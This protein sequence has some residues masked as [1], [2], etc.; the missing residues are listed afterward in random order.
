MEVGAQDFE[1]VLYLL[2]HQFGVEQEEAGHDGEVLVGVVDESGAPEFL[3]NGVD[4]LRCDVLV[5]VFAV[6]QHLP[7]FH[8]VS[9]SFDDECDAVLEEVAFGIA[10]AVLEE[11]G[12]FEEVLA[13]LAYGRQESWFA[14]RLLC[15]VEHPLVT[16]GVERSMVFVG[17]Q[18]V[19][20]SSHVP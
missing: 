20:E 19:G 16:F 2:L 7:C 9:Y 6:V 5:L 8:E 15:D 13:L 12:S 11:F 1:N 17:Q 10:G 18:H 4:E 14:F 3:E